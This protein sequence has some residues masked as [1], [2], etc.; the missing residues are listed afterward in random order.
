MLKRLRLALFLVCL[1]SPLVVNA[2]VMPFITSSQYPGYTKET[3]R[4]DKSICGVWVEE[5]SGDELAITLQKDGSY[6]VSTTSNSTLNLFDMELAARLF[7][8]Q[9]ILLVDLVPLQGSLCRIYPAGT[10]CFAAVLP[11]G[12]SLTVTLID[13]D[14]AAAFI[15]GYPKKL[16]FVEYRNGLLLVEPT[17]VLQK[18][19][20]EIVVKPGSAYGTY[21]FKRK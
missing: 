8:L 13:P 12:N 21:I 17:N 19:L 14:F 2:S 11:K 18:L 16:K 6:H 5:E 15:R 10:H 20:M 9:K 4:I 1:L 7:Q 3:S